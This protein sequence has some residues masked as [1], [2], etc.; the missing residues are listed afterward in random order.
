[1]IKNI[2]V[3]DKQGNLIGTTYP[4]RAKG[5]VKNGR[6]EYISGCEI[7]LNTHAPIANDTE[8]KNM[9]KVIN[10]NAREFRFDKRCDNN[11]GSRFFI[12]DCFGEGTEVFEIGN[13]GWD[14]T[15]IVCEKQLEKNTDYIFR[16]AMTGG[17]CD[18]RDET[19]QFVI[20]PV[21]EDEDISAA[22]ENRY[23]YSLAQSEYKPALSKR[24]GSGFIRIY[25]IPF[26]TY[27]C[28]RFAFAFI[29]MHAAAKIF[30][31]KELS[32]YA[33]FEDLSCDE[34]YAQRTNNLYGGCPKSSC[35]CSD[36]ANMS[37]NNTNM[38]ESELAETL[39][40]LGD[41]CN[42]QLQNVNIYSVENGACLNIGGQSD[43][44]NFDLSNANLTSRALSMLVCKLGD[45]CIVCLNNANVTAE[46][47]D[48]MYSVGNKSDG[49]N[50][51]LNNA[52]LPGAVVNLIKS[53]LGDGCN[54]DLSQAEIL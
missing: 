30:P 41:G 24:W 49:V 19:S 17:I 47:I 5:L 35:Y 15:Q 22:W 42:V 34:Y 21:A 39:S 52:K 54:L 2:K 11:V 4:K 27:D 36:G 31:A 13:W 32:A 18:T 26:N 48:N 38:S 16:F 9:S 20:C 37:F 10:F 25:E 50:I 43:G 40:N 3:T 7:Q 46:G 12:T 33:D 29:A 51:D 23:T 44:S 45:G 8:D 6:A 28:E 53:K 1:M 14:W